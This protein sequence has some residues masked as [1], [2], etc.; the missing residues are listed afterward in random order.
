MASTIIMLVY[1]NWNLC[2]CDDDKLILLLKLRPFFQSIK[3]C[4]NQAQKQIK[5][6]ERI[7]GLT[8]YNRMLKKLVQSLLNNHSFVNNFVGFTIKSNV[9]PLQCTLRETCQYF[10]YFR[11]NFTTSIIDTTHYRSTV[12]YTHLRAHET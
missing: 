3:L 1:T 5:L 2:P 6:T 12:S 9:N 7:F 11:K 8:N 10:A 4:L